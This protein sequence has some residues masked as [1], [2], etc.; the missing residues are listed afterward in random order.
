MANPKPEE[1]KPEELAKIE[2][3]PQK[4]GWM[5]T[6]T[7]FKKGMFCYGNQPKFLEMVGFPNARHWSILDEDWKLPENWQEIF[8]EGDTLVYAIGMEA[9]DFRTEELK[10][11]YQIY[12]IGDSIQPRRIQDAVSE[13]YPIAIKI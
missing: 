6:P 3:K 12:K 13:A 10:R 2:Y 5:D 9:R 1:L 7:V 8:I 11:K 4:T